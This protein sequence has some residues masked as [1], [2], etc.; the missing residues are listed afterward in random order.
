MVQ[1]DFKFL[2]HEH[3]FERKNGS[4]IARDVVA[5]SA[6]YGPIGWVLERLILKQHM[7]RFLKR[8]NEELKRIAELQAAN[9][10]KSWLQQVW[11][12]EEALGG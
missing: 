1:G 4:T 10:S 12:E 2:R 8:K 5:F 9:S 11:A 6:P 3:R 7:E